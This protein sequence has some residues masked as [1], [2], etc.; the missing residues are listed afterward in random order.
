[1]E[2]TE[3]II[4]YVIIKQKTSIEI[5]EV[6]IKR[7]PTCGPFLLKAWFYVPGEKKTI[8]GKGRPGR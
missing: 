4:E 3:L 7:D 1:V 5:H 2:E 6:K 8:N